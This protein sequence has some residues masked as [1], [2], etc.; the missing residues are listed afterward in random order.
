MSIKILIADDHLLLRQGIRMVLDLEDDLEVVAEAV[1]GHETLA[2]TMMLQ[3]DILLLDLNMPILNGIEVTQ[4]LQTA[5]ID[6]KIIMLTIHDDDNYVI[7]VLKNGAMGYLLKDVEP[8]MLIKAIHMVHGGSAFVYPE[9]AEKLFGAA[10]CEN[11]G[12]R[13]EEIWRER[14]SERLTAREMDVLRCIAKG[15][16]NQEIAQALFVSEKTVK[17]HLTNIFRKINV[18]DRTQALLYA[19]KNKIMTLE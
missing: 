13:A 18:N 7:E 5:Q 6:T 4:R 2:K 16:S 17:N 15:F 8:E 14:R 10:Q 3:P 19:L 11:V 12:D 1:D 9:I